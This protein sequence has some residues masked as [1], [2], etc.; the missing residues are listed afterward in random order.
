MLNR[1]STIRTVSYEGVSF[2]RV[3]LY[4]ILRI[5]NCGLRNKQPMLVKNYGVRIVDFASQERS[6]ELNSQYQFIL[7]Y[8]FSITIC[9]TI[10]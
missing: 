9:I 6:C 2:R 4:K 5:A 10:V 8:F 3:D 7:P 1:L